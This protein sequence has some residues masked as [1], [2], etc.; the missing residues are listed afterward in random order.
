VRVEARF[1]ERVSALAEHGFAVGVRI[2][3]AHDARHARARLCRR[4]RGVASR[5][6]VSPHGG[7]FAISPHGGD[8]AISPNG[9]DERFKT[10]RATRTTAETRA[11]PLG[12][13]GAR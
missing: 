8:F 2:V 11:R 1:A 13:D 10:T 4:A 9:G 5:I 6:C 12:D 3:A 7:D